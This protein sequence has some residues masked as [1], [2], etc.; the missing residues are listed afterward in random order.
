MQYRGSKNKLAK[1]ILEHLPSGKYFIEPFVG[2]GNMTRHAVESNKFEI[3]LCSDINDYVIE[4]FNALKNGWFPDKHY[5]REQFN[6]MKV[7][8]RNKD[9]SKYSKAEICTVGFSCDFLAKFL[10]SYHHGKN[11]SKPYIKPYT[12]AEKDIKFVNACEF[13]CCSYKEIEI[14]EKGCIIYCDPPYQSVQG[15]PTGVFDHEEFYEWAKEMS[16]D[17]HVYVSEEN[18]PAGWECIWQKEIKKN[19]GITRT[20]IEKLFTYKN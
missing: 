7:Y 19:G 5:S 9:Y 2:G 4:Y 14:P 8:H 17:H 18:M 10:T 15:Y 1:Y 6:E 16:K 12:N 11:G 13:Q 3:F 20:R